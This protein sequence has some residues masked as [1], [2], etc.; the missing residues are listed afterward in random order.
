MEDVAVLYVDT[1]SFTTHFCTFI[2]KDIESE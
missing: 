2:G 1:R